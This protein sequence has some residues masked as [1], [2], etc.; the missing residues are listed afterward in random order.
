[1]F[2]TSSLVSPLQVPPSRHEDPLAEF[3]D[4]PA[5]FDSELLEPVPPLHAEDT[6]HIPYKGVQFDEEEMVKRAKEFYEFMNKRRSV[7]HFSSKSVPKK[8]VENIIHTAG[9]RAY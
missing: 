8:V 5:K 7:R 3:D 1:M 2:R 9:M 4:D 6:A